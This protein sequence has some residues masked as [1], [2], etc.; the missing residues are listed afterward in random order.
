MT[1]KDSLHHLR[2]EHEGALLVADALLNATAQTA[3]CLVEA[4]LEFFDDFSWE[5]LVSEEAQLLPT[6]D[7]VDPA[8]A[9]RVRA[10]HE[11]LR[12]EAR[13]LRAG[14]P[15]AQR[16]QALGRLLRGHI[17][18]EEGQLYPRFDAPP[19]PAAAAG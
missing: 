9:E 19:L 15:D 6:V 18:L 14:E 16:L 10:E 5:H 7:R 11:Q 3:P 2:A 17:R 8:L 4:F 12:A 1:P 13:L